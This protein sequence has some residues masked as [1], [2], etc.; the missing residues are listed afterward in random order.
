MAS[1][2]EIA[3]LADPVRGHPEYFQMAAGYWNKAADKAGMIHSALTS[4]VGD[5][6]DSALEGEAAKAIKK[7]L[8]D[9]NTLLKDMPD[10]CRGLGHLLTTHATKLTTLKEAAER[11]RAR[12]ATA[13]QARSEA[14][15]EDRTSGA[16]LASLTAQ[17]RQLQG[18]PDEQ[19]ASRVNALEYELQV[20]RGVKAAA[21]HRRTAHQAEI[22][23]ETGHWDSI[24]GEERLLNTTTAEALDHVALHTLG[25][26]SNLAKIGHGLAA[27]GAAFLDDIKKAGDIGAWIKDIE[28]LAH[29]FLT[30]EWGQVLWELRD[31]LDRYIALVTIVLLVAVIVVLVVGAFF[32]AGAT[33]AA[34]P[35][36]ITVLNFTSLALSASKMALDLL[37][38][39]VAPV[40]TETGEKMTMTT[41]GADT[42]GMLLAFLGLK[43]PVGGTGLARYNATRQALSEE[44]IVLKHGYDVSVK[45]SIKSVALHDLQAEAKDSPNKVAGILADEG[46][47]PTSRTVP[48]DEGVRQLFRG[49]AG[50]SGP[51]DPHLIPSY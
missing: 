7:L 10:V 20:E 9:T 29:A 38:I 3:E 33:L 44:G 30:G 6:Q 21:H 45:A 25:D 34:L 18:A 43:A 42:I 47:Q 51:L 15:D 37:I 4:I 22:D 2:Y 19:S 27:F 13:W 40:N 26:P 49:Y 50:L 17:I 11:A 23:R 16:R 1:W 8:V 28:Q 32:T 31:V 12:A 39:N 46:R 14:D 48:I 24:R 5:A 35:E 41:I 36:L